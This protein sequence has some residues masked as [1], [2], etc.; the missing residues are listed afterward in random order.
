MMVVLMMVNFD[1]FPF[2]QGGEWESRQIGVVSS[3]VRLDSIWTYEELSV[4]F[5]YTVRSHYHY[6]NII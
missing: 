4:L 3:S 6:E 2:L 5:H 1:V